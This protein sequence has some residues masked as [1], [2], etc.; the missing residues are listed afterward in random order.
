M[1]NIRIVERK[2]LDSDYIIFPTS[3][4]NPLM[5]LKA[6]E[7]K[8]SKEISLPSKILVD[9]LLCNGNNFNRFVR[10]VFDGK[11]IDRSS[12]EITKLNMAEETD[13]NEF[14]RQNKNLISKG[15]LAPSEYLQYV[16]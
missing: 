14:Y 16:K 15:V 7:N 8:L 3:Y 10:F 13:V 5:D 11:K 2:V 4:I 6:L 12:I 1:R 9:L